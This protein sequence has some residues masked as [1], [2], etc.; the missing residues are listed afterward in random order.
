MRV[1]LLENVHALGKAGEIVE[2][3]DGYGKNFL[4]AQNKAKLAT[5]DVVRQFEAGVRAKAELDAFNLAKARQ[6]AK[7]FETLVLKVEAKCGEG[8]ALFGAVT[9]DEIAN[10]LATLHNIEL[11]KKSI[12]FIAPIKQTGAHT[13]KVKLGNG[14]TPELKIEVIALDK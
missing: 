8:G 4:I 12:D 3:K 1:L 10:T 14:I 9:K 5:K 11:D 6:I 7:E 13:V 2:V